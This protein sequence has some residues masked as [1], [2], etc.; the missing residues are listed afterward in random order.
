MSLFRIK[1]HVEKY[2]EKKKKYGVYRFRRSILY[3]AERGFKVN[4]NEK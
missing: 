1:Q 3:S 4:F 2:M